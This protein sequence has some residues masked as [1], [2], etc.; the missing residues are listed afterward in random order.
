MDK[1]HGR[2][3]WWFPRITR[4]NVYVHKCFYGNR[5]MIIGS[6]ASY[7][8]V[9][10]DV[11]EVFIAA[12]KLSKVCS[13]YKNMGVHVQIHRYDGITW[14]VFDEVCA[15]LQWELLPRYQIIRGKSI[16]LGF[17]GQIMD[18]WISQAEI[19]SAW[20]R[21]IELVRDF[22]RGCKHGLQLKRC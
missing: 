11:F 19:R 2:Y 6:L 16:L 18:G 13:W 3:L 7:I 10:Y 22:S 15:P 20:M 1:C 9:L 21:Y 8:G 12:R 4:P 5:K 17:F 14:I